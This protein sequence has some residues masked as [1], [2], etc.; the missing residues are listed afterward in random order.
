[1]RTIGGMVRRLRALV[2]RRADDAELDEEI[3]FHLERETE[4]LIASGAP[5]AEARRRALVAFGGVQRARESHREVRGLPRLER[6]VADVRHAARVLRRAPAMTAAAVL[7]LALGI[8]ANTAIF[9]AVSAVL[10]RPLPYANP[11]RLVMLWDVNPEKGWYQQASSPAN[12]L[13]WTAGVA[14][15]RDVAM[16]NNAAGRVSLAAGD[17]PRMVNILRVTGNFFDVL[18]VR[19]AHGRVLRAEETWDSTSQALVISDRLFRSR[20]GGDASVVGRVVDVAGAPARIVGVMP[21]GFAYPDAEVDGWRPMS[22]PSSFKGQSFFRRAHWVRPIARLRPGA[23]VEQAR[24]QLAT[25]AKR[26]QHDY[27]ELDRNMDAGLSPLHRFLVGDTRTPLLVLLVAVGVLLLIACANVGNL[28]LVHA[29][30]REREGAL[31]LALGAGRARLVRTAFTESLLVAMIGAGVGVALGV[32]GT[33]ALVAMRPPGL[34]AVAHVGVDW[35]VL[36][37]VAAAAVGS[38]LLLGTLPALGAAERDPADALRAGVRS[39]GETRRMRRW[40]DTLAVAELALSLVLTI[41][42]GLCVRSMRALQQTP[43]GFEAAGVETLTIDLPAGGDRYDTGDEVNAFWDALRRRVRTLPG[44]TDVA[45]VGAL[46]LSTLNYSSSFTAEGRSTE[47]FIPEIRH[48]QVSPDYFR[49]MRVTLLRGRAFTAQDGASAPRVVIV[50]DAVARTYFRGRDPVGQRVAFDR[51]PDSTTTWYTVVGVVADAQQRALGVPTEMQ[52]YVPEAQEPQ[53]AMSLVARTRGDPAALAPALRAA[54]REIDPALAISSIT[55]MT[56]VVRASL[57]R[58]RFLMTLM[59]GFAGVGLLLAL[60]GIYGVLAQL[61]RRRQR[62][63]GIRI[64][65]GA[66]AHRVRWLVVGHALR[67]VVIAVVIGGGVAL[68]ATRALRSVLYGVQPADPLTFAVVIILLAG[69]AL[70]ASWIP[71]VRASRADPAMTLRE[72]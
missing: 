20:F 59:F 51:I 33:H 38:G 72:E 19:A 43:P 35:R 9:S 29:L 5:P 10:L 58:E 15:F 39:G 2:S 11:D 46:P 30:G 25:V 70:V 57:D 60:V 67:L 36:L 4:R 48:Q 17:E 14:A 52:C 40:G 28:L 69:A 16:A 50:N 18:G 31:R 55:P 49:A 41:G 53:S 65:L 71:A 32:W 1:M 62:E 27:P 34:R 42:A 47:D 12:V 7:T 26:L 44:V 6:I 13:D 56:E 37:F 64:A 24:A 3:A 54:V 45:T 61:A 22:W 66:M 8:G 21:P 23:T 63:M 68:L